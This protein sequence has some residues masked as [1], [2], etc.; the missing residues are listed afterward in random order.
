VVTEDVIAPFGL[1][2][3]EGQ[4]FVE[5]YKHRDKADWTEAFI[6]GVHKRVSALL[7]AGKPVIIDGAVANVETLDDLLAGLPDP[8]ILYLHPE[9]VKN[10]ERNLTSRFMDASPTS[11]A[12]LPARFW[13]LVNPDDFTEFYKTKVINKAIASAISDYAASSRA[14]SA[15]R[16]QALQD[17][18]DN[19]IVANL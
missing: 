9:N 19:I 17:H 7:D 11:N 14:E 3:E 8:V 13:D 4:V 5:I 6:Q 12:G 18:F 15:T 10:Y 16:L 1:E 2:A